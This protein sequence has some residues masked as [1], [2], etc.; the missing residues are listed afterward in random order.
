MADCFHASYTFHDACNYANTILERQSLARFSP[1]CMCKSV[2]RFN[3]VFIG[4][5]AQITG[6]KSCGTTV[7]CLMLYVRTYLCTSIPYQ[8]SYFQFVIDMYFA[9]QCS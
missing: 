3:A 1:H 8:P 7:V 9:L 5:I 4:S 2:C 6:Q